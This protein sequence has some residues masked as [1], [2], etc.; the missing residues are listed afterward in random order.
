MSSHPASLPARLIQRFARFVAPRHADLVRGM[1][2]ELEVIAEPAERRRFAL[3]ALAAI[4]RLSVGQRLP[5]ASA[6]PGRSLPV[7]PSG[8]GGP[9]MSPT[10]HR[11]LA[12]R[13]LVPFLLSFIGLT[14][15][16]LSMFWARVASQ[17]G[18]RGASVGVMVEAVALGLPFTMAMTVPMAVFLSVTWVFSRPGAQDILLGARHDAWALR[19][20]LLPVLLGASLIAALMF[21][22]NTMVLPRANSRLMSVMAGAPTQPTDRTMSVDELRAAAQQVRAT[23]G[24]RGEARAAAYEVEVQKKFAMSAACIVLA[25]AAVT[26]SL[27]FPRGGAWL[28]AGSGVVV[29][30]GYYIALI[31][32]ETLADRLVVSPV[33]AMWMANALVLVLAWLLV[34]PVAR[35]HE[36]P[37][38]S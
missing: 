16:F 27:R 37:L 7:I 33:V 18:E 26:I 22:S 24:A 28:V 30:M 5:R 1:L 15:V 31:A 6:A 32:G 38:A 11:Q 20:L 23:A 19:Q 12:G 14:A 3:G 10:T 35:T 4:V 29:F 9:R 17:L 25:L 8:P 2:A 36:A 34:R 21:V 13:H